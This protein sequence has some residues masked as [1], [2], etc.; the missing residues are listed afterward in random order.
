VAN[1]LLTPD[2]LEQRLL[3]FGI[4]VCRSLLQAEHDFVLRHIALQLVRCSTSPAAN[5]GEA[6][7]AESRRDFIHKMQICLKELRETAIWLR[8]RSGI[9]GVV[10]GS[11]EI[12][13]ECQELMLIVGAGIRTARRSK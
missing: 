4:A 3:A 6:R 5:Y 1:H 12:A 13:R 10:K 11:E 2:Q 9:Y 8:F 7:A